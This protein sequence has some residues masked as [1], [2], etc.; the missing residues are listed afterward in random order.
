[1]GRKIPTT[2][3][4]GHKAWATNKWLLRATTRD[5]DRAAHGGPVAFVL[6]GP[7]GRYASD[8]HRMHWIQD[9]SGP[10]E[11][12]AED[13]RWLMSGGKLERAENASDKAIRAAYEGVRSVVTY[14]IKGDVT[15]RTVKASDVKV[16]IAAARG[17]VK[18]RPNAKRTDIAIVRLFDGPGVQ[19]QYLEDAIGDAVTVTIA[20]STDAYDPI[21]VSWQKELDG[22]AVA[23]YLALVMPH[24]GDGH[25]T[26]DAAEVA[27]EA[28]PRD[29]ARK[30]R[31]VARKVPTLV[32]AP[33]PT[34]P[35]MTDAE[36]DA[37]AGK[38]DGSTIT[39]SM[40][41]GFQVTG[42]DGEDLGPADTMI[43]AARIA[44]RASEARV[45]ARDRVRHFWCGRC[46]RRACAPL[47]TAG[48][49]C[50]ACQP[51]CATIAAAA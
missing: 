23:D 48:K 18:A 8:G 42:P 33:A 4:E 25:A 36:V 30:P 35:V 44:F 5:F 6:F 29:G 17:A 41:T 34:P 47:G 21:K 22:H 15:L 27:P 40:D 46:H 16:A 1:M 49:I 7:T 3:P 11:P 51:A 50:P 26:L 38:C 12:V 20:T 13:V 19:A 14:G 39:G 28:A 31:G 45:E 43:A 32:I 37:A 9:A 2:F 24:K 10:S